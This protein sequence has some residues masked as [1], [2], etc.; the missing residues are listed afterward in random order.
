MFSVSW[1]LAW[2]SCILHLVMANFNGCH[3]KLRPWLCYEC[4][5]WFQFAISFNGRR[6]LSHILHSLFIPDAM[7]GF[8]NNWLGSSAIRMSVRKRT[9]MDPAGD[10][11]STLVNLLPNCK[12]FYYCC[13]FGREKSSSNESNLIPF[14]RIEPTH[15]IAN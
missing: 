9:E 13:C 11:C 14:K 12:R 7:Y 3:S 6:L 15:T 4:L 8:W 5:I 1:A 10:H 2:N